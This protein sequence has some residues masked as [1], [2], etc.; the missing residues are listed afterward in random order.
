MRNPETTLGIQ[1]K[2]LLRQIELST[3]AAVA[4]AV[5]A[6]GRTSIE[7]YESHI[8]A[9]SVR[10]LSQVS[11]SSSLLNEND[12]GVVLSMSHHPITKSTTL[13][14]SSYMKVIVIDRYYE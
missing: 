8:E 11:S 4:A 13:G 6:R 14:M 5:A 3:A 10:N 1:Q 2:L 7:T 12:R 9:Q